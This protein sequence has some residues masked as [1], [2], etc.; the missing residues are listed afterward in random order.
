MYDFCSYVIKYVA[1][2]E[3]LSLEGGSCQVVRTLKQPYKE[4]YMAE[5]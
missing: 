5:N 2:F 1:L 4:V 3:L